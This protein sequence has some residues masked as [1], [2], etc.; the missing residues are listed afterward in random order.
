MCAGGRGDDVI[1]VA[2]FLPTLIHEKFHTSTHRNRSYKDETLANAKNSA[3]LKSELKLHH[4]NLRKLNGE[5][6]AEDSE[7]DTTVASKQ[8][9]QQ[10]VMDDNNSFTSS[11]LH[12]DSSDDEQ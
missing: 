12:H 10:H 7:D 1:G 5:E 8:H 4:N 6:V 2:P 9:H 11:V 3:Q